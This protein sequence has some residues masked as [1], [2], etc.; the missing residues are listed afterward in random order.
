MID[1]AIPDQ[2]HEA[3]RWGDTETLRLN[4][5]T[6]SPKTRMVL[7][8][9]AKRHLT[10]TEFDLLLFLASHPGQVFTRE[11][12]MRNVWDYSIPV[13]CSTVTVHI[14]RL[15]EKVEGSPENPQYIKTVWGA[16]YKFQG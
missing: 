12:L 2:T 10:A 13:D 11:E 1:S 3:D 6:I 7:K 5:L 8:D 16:G 9:G 15:R 14:R 4:G